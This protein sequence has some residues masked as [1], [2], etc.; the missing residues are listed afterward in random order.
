MKGRI[1]M[2]TQPDAPLEKEQQTAA[3]SQPE[4]TVEQA[5]PTDQ[6]EKAQQAS[7][8][9]T[10]DTPDTS[11]APEGQ[12]GEP[13][14][15]ALMAENAALKARLEELNNIHQR[16][17]AEYANYKRR[18]EQ[19]KEQI[20]L[21]TKCDILKALLPTVDSFERAAGAPVGEDY[22]AGIE[23]IVAGFLKTLQQLGLEEI[24]AENQ[25]FD[26]ELHHAVAREDA[27]D[28]E[29]EMV[30]EVFQ[31]GYKVGD[32]VI[33]PAMVKVANSL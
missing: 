12:S 29:V 9:D 27:P 6:E 1:N 5:P 30:T 17:L 24:P 18:T 13:D 25:P 20:G 14:I 3:G 8:P 10:S 4:E 23:M 32:R 16:V 22:K 11:D 28:L 7:E 26:P 33:R 2:K 19:E 15:Q 21:F 31:K